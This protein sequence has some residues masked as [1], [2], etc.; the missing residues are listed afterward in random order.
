VRLLQLRAIAA[1]CLTLGAFHAPAA[2]SEGLFVV[3]HQSCESLLGRVAPHFGLNDHEVT[4]VRDSLDNWV[5]ATFKIKL[6]SINHGSAVFV[7]PSGQFFTAAHVGFSDGVREIQVSDVAPG[8]RYFSAKRRLDLRNERVERSIGRDFTQGLARRALWHSE[9]APKGWIEVDPTGGDCGERV[10]V[11]G[12]PDYTVR[13]SSQ[14]LVERLA[15]EKRVKAQHNN[16]LNFE[17]SLGPARARRRHLASEIASVSRLEGSTGEYD[18]IEQ[19]Q[20]GV[21]LA[22]SVG[23]VR[24]LD[25][26]SGIADADAIPGMS[27]GPV[28]SLKTGELLGVVEAIDSQGSG[29]GKLMSRYRFPGAVHF[30]RPPTGLRADVGVSDCQK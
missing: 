15:W 19:S 4:L 10:I 20:V 30:Q 14:D 28:I 27:G 2:A 17:K 21:A 5:R 6:D 13:V 26:E 23:T 1:A 18:R 24:H 9:H 12:F 7:G 8:G 11:L 22:F 16:A 29:N 3:N 25:A